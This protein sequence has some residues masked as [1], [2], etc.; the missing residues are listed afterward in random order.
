MKVFALPNVVLINISFDYGLE[1]ARLSFPS[2]R[3][4]FLPCKRS[5]SDVFLVFLLKKCLSV[6]PSLQFPVLSWVELSTSLKA[7]WRT[8]TSRYFVLQW[9]LN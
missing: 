6:P 1:P 8:L 2:L 7:D 4:S 9:L 5:I 3:P